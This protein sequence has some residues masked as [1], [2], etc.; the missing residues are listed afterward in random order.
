MHTNMKR[1]LFAS[2]QVADVFNG[3]V[4]RVD[5]GLVVEGAP[6]K[7]LTDVNFRIAFLRGNPNGM[8]DPRLQTGNNLIWLER[9]TARL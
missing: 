8:P 1:G 5:V 4:S 3:Y 6:P 2:N 7:L 9:D